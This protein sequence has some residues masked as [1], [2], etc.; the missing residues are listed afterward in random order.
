MAGASKEFAN[1][2]LFASLGY[3]YKEDYFKTW[4]VGFETSVRCFSFGLKYV[5][6][7]YPML[8]TRGAEARD[9][10]YV[11]LTIRFIPL[12]SS[13]VKVGR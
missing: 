1:L 5:S 6:E 13:D 3:D 11:L 8:T 10:K 4:Q 2:N 9:D 7:V 12:L